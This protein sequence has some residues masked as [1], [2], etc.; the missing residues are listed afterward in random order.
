MKN[1][2]KSNPFLCSF[3]VFLLFVL[4]TVAVAI[5]LFYY[6]FSIPE[7]EGLS[8]ASWPQRF[9]DNFSAWID[10]KDGS[11]EIEK[12]GLERLDEYGLWIQV[13]DESGQEI[14]SYKKPENYPTNYP[15]SALTALNTSA[16]AHGNTVFVGS[17]DDSGEVCSYIVG[18][19]YA[20]GK[21]MLYYDGERIARLLPAAKTIV[22]SAPCDLF[23]RFFHSMPA[24]VC[25]MSKFSTGDLGKRK[26]DT[27]ITFS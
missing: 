3:A 14:F 19:P 27:Q 22:L 8:L 7:P 10:Y 12:I 1:K 26:A 2:Q 17:F 18:F 13:I 23:F 15:A 21:Y 6:M 11:V 5:G 9:M 16:Y 4:L 25:V 24:A 20:I